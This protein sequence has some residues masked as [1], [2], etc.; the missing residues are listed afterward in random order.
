MFHRVFLPETNTPQIELPTELA[1]RMGCN[2]DQLKVLPDVAVQALDIAKD[3]N[4]SVTRFSTVVEQD[5]KLTTDILRMA[6]TVVFS[7]GQRITSLHQAII[8]LGFRHCKNLILS[9]CIGSLMRRMSIQ[10]TNS[11][12]KL[13]KHGFLTALISANLN[14]LFGIRFMGEDFTAGLIHDLGRTLLAMFMPTEFKQFDKLDFVEDQYLLEREHAALGTTHC[15][16]G[17]WFVQHNMLPDPL[18]QVVRFHHQPELS[19]EG[20][21]LTTLVAA[22]DEIANFVHQLGAPRELP[23]DKLTMLVKLEEVG[24]DRAIEKFADQSTQIVTMA[25]SDLCSLNSRKS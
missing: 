13:Y 18:C 19:G 12:E 22:S 7:G 20:R 21:L 6:N 5:V 3:P 1:L 24:V 15:D 10:E 14:N 9:S 25:L 4:C 23:I 17:G 8:R 2:L 11:R 16:V